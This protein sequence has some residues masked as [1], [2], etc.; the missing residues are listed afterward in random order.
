MRGHEH[1]IAL[2]LKRLMPEAI[3]IDDYSFPSPNID[4]HENGEFPHVCVKGD[5]I[6]TLD[7]RFLIGTQ[8][9]ISTESES[10]GK[11]LL[12][13]CKKHGATTV[14]ACQTVQTGPEKFET[15]WMEHYYG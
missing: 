8:V 3:F 5:A 9:H 4:W 2:R 6:E 11:A 13:A 1:I 15:K 10:R 7:L 12:K 14:I